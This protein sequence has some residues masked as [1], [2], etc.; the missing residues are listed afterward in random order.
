[1]DE[2]VLH[3]KCLHSICKHY[4]QLNTPSHLLF[5]APIDILQFYQFSVFAHLL[6]HLATANFSFLTI[7]KILGT[8]SRGYS[9]VLSI[10]IYTW[11]LSHTFVR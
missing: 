10:K 6:P 9:V 7:F 2:L 1:M 8:C 3:Q 11:N 4:F 5:R